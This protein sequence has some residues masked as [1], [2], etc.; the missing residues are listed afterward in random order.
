MTMERDLLVEIKAVIESE[1]VG[2]PGWPGCGVGFGGAR[3][4]FYRRVSVRWRE[5]AVDTF[6]A[7]LPVVK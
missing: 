1:D 6:I 3:L 4:M 5:I 2:H 7:V